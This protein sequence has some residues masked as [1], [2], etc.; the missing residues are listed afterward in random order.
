MDLK[1]IVA[2]SGK[3]GLFQIIA[4]TKSGLIV[5]SIE[6][7]AKK[8]PVSTNHQ[9]AILEDV[10]I[11]AKQNKEI[12]LKDIFVNILKQDG[13]KIP[14]KPNDSPAELKTYFEKVAPEYDEDRVYNSDIKKV[15][16]WFNLLTDHKIIT[17]KDIEKVAEQKAEAEKEDAKD[18][19]KV[20]DKENEVKSGS[21]DKKAKSTSVSSAKTKAKTKS[22]KKSEK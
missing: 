11:F 8:L 4:E 1:K 7:P 12:S 16:K 3:S 22:K 19:D 6:E 10:S 13:E 14:V 15:V 18:K 9:V 20:K 17:V 5:S 2:V 21:S